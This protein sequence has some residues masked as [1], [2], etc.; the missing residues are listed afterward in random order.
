ME[1]VILVA[2]L[3]MLNTKKMG[4]YRKQLAEA[5]GRAVK[6]FGKDK[7]S[8][9]MAQILYETGAKQSPLAKL[10]NLTGIIFVG[11]KGAKDSG[12]LLPENKAYTYAKY[13]SVSDW[14][15]D[16]IRIVN[17]SVK[18]SNSLYDYASNLKK[19][20]YYTAPLEDYRKALIYFNNNLNKY[21]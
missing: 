11:Q 6:E 1:L 5:K 20:G 2:I 8:W 12:I 9:V 15:F 14:F 17:K 7:A 10:N 19:Q 4:T 18:N 3:I 21:V 16:Y 13:N